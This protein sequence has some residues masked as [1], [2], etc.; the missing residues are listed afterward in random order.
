MISDPLYFFV[1]SVT[2][3]LVGLC[4]GEETPTVVPLD[5]WPAI[6]SGATGTDSRIKSKTTSALSYLK[7]CRTAGFD[8]LQL[9]CT[10]CA[11][12]LEQHQDKCKECCQSY[13]TLEKRTKR[14]E[15]AVL[16]NT[17]FP[18]SVQELVRD[19]MDTILEQKGSGRFHVR[20]YGVNMDNMMGMM[21]RQQ[22]SVIF[23]FDKPI[24]IDSAIEEMAEKADELTV[25]SGRGLGRDDMR[26]MLLTLLPDSKE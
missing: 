26:D 18:E 16:L 25:I 9:A 6:D 3:L 11:I 17:G 19:D 22:P 13:R 24:S 15:M 2:V 5:N 21:F 7:D 8:P 23:W 12:L 20:D 1:I 14:Y 4:R 10:T